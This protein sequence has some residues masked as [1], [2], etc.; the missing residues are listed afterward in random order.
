MLSD[1]EC[2][3][4]CKAVSRVLKEERE[5]QGLSKNALSEA[6]GISRSA[7]LKI[8]EGERSP[9]LDTLFRLSS[10]LKIQPN[11]L[12]ERAESP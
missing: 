5:R 10:A 8:E 9:T 3:K 2:E 6:S 12:L 1:N 4:L 11:K 7:L